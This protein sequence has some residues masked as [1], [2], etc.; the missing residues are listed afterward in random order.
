MWSNLI[1]GHFFTVLLLPLALLLFFAHKWEPFSVQF[2]LSPFFLLLVCFFPFFVSSHL[3]IFALIRKCVI[4]QTRANARTPRMFCLWIDCNTRW[5]WMCKKNPTTKQNEKKYSAHQQKI[6]Q[7]SRF[8]AFSYYTYEFA[9][10]RRKLSLNEALNTTT[11]DLLVMFIF[12]YFIWIFCCCCFAFVFA[13]SFAAT[14][15][16][17]IF[18]GVIRMLLLPPPPGIAY[19]WTI[20]QVE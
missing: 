9:V 12:I 2:S 20:R 15:C 14:V 19:S 10:S 5:R 11:F 13:R 16:D 18:C 1:P 6:E 4:K 7:D 3:V 8:V 17:V